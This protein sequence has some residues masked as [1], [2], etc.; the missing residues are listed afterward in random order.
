LGLAQALGYTFFDRSGN[1]LQPLGNPGLN[2]LNLID[3]H[4]FRPPRSPVWKNLRILALADVQIPLNGV[5]G[6]ARTFGPQKFANEHE[7]QYLEKGFQNLTRVWRRVLGRDCEGP[8]SGAAGGLG[9]GMHVFLGGILVSGAAWCGKVAGLDDAIRRNQVVFTGE[10]RLD[11]TTFL[12]KAP[13]WV[14]RRARRF[15]RPIVATVE[16]SQ[17]LRHPLFSHIQRMDDSRGWE[18]LHRL[19]FTNSRKHA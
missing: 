10:G 11:A 12:G 5:R 9:A 17:I 3:V 13:M 8:G 4:S 7:V 16:T 14:A 1:R 19:L 15:G 18:N 6:Q 2:A